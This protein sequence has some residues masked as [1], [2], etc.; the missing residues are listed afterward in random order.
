MTM[1]QLKG[2]EYD[3]VLLIED[4]HRTFRG[5]DNEPPYMET[6]GQQRVS[7]T[8]ARHFACVLSATRNAALSVIQ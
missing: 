3:A 5:R 1:H 8:R 2:G 7:L 6:R 4:K